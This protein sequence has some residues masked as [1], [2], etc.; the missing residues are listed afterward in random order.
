MLQLGRPAR[1]R[2]VGLQQLRDLPSLR[3]DLPA[4]RRT[5]TINSSRDNSSGPDTGRSNPTQ[6]NTL[7][8]T[9]ITDRYNAPVPIMLAHHPAEGAECLRFDT[10]ATIRL[11]SPSRSPPDA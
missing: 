5:T 1:Q 7:I 4:W 3:A 8:D 10:S 9:P 2:L 6:I 11:R